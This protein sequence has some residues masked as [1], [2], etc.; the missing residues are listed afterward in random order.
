MRTFAADV[1]AAFDSG[2]FTPIIRAWGSDEGVPTVA[3]QV[4]YFR[5]HGIEAEVRIV[6]DLGGYNLILERGLVI[7]GVETTIFST[8]F[9]PYETSKTRGITT[10]KANILT[11][12]VF[13]HTGNV[14]YQTLL[15]YLASFNQWATARYKPVAPTWLGYKFFPVGK[16][17]S[18]NNVFS[19]LNLLHQKYFIF[20]TDGDN[21][22]ILFYSATD[23]VNTASEYTIAYNELDVQRYINENRELR[24]RDE[25]ETIHSLGSTSN[26][27][28]N[29]GY[30]ESTDAAPIIPVRGNVHGSTYTTPANLKYMSG[31]SV[32]VS[33]NGVVETQP[34]C[35]D[36]VEIFEPN[37]NNM[38]WRMELSPLWY[39]T[40][41]AGGAMPSTIERVANYTPLNTSYFDGV[42]SP[43]DNNVQAA[44]DTLDNHDH[45]VLAPIAAPTAISDF[46]VG[47]QVTGVWSW[48]KKTLAE[49]KTILGL[50]SA[51]YTASSDYPP[52]A[53][54]ISTT[55]PLT[56]GG[57]LSANKTIAIPAATAAAAGH[58]TAAQITKLDAIAAGSQVNVLEGVTGTAPIVAG[59]IAAKSQAIS[60]AA[61]S[62]SVPGSMSAAD[63]ASLRDGWI[64]G[65]GTW[66]Y[67]TATTITVP[68]GAA[69]IYGIGDKIRFQN[70]DSG[71]YL[72]AYIVTVAD[73]LLTVKGGAVPSATLTDT[74][75]SKAANPLG[76]PHW[77]AWTVTRSVSGGT[78]PSYTSVDLSRFEIKGRTVHCQITWVNLTGGTAGA[79][80][81]ALTFTLPVTASTAGY[82]S[83]N[84]VFGTGWAYEAAGTATNIVV[85]Y[86]TG[87]TEGRFTTMPGIASLVGNDQSSD[88]RRISADFSYEI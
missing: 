72:Y 73:T 75:Y 24:W 10:I 28:H 52:V 71:T 1:Q 18:L 49:V 61:A 81:N 87:G 82:S 21:G 38:A 58:A 77:F 35:L 2:N 27:M 11:K 50:G 57:D 60:I 32:Y 3:L 79:G 40:A 59:A 84:S 42:L 8:E 51:A 54:T 88:D 34:T 53:R 13:S 46:L 29:L 5:L 20:A 65:T 56:G 66:T 44:F 4:T 25:V 45:D 64:P 80:T 30:L 70:N 43:S 67:A 19:I 14:T 37:T 36:V 69:A 76:F 78:A 26:P 48:V 31:D 55:A 16:T 17:V 23:I 15:T 62:A 39:L 41:T 7:A 6:G 74:Y 33:L 47:A 22:T 63:F 12:S 9:V 86:N 68:S 85:A 83:F